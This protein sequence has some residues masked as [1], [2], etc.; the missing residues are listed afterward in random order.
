MCRT[1]TK[2]DGNTSAQLEEEDEGA[3]VVRWK[4]K[5]NQKSLEGRGRLTDKQ[6]DKIQ[7]QYGNVI[8]RNKNN[9]VKMRTQVWAVYFL[10]LSCDAKPLHHLCSPNCPYR[11]AQAESE[12]KQHLYKHRGNLPAAVVDLIKRVFQD[13]CKPELLNK[14]LAGYTQNANESV[15]NT[16]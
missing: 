9:I 5:T 16:I 11:K 3:T 6:I 10:K 1:R 12:N 14:C 4:Q 8:R 2:E 7:N 15:N 13:L